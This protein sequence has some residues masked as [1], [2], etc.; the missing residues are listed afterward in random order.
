MAQ[1]PISRTARRPHRS[2]RRVV[3]TLG[4]AL[5]A[6]FVSLLPALPAQAKPTPAQLRAQITAQ[7]KV[8]EPI[9]EQYNTLRVKLADDQAKS[10]ALAKQLGPAQLLATTA[11]T[12]LG[13]IASTIYQSGGVSTAQ[14]LIGA[15]GSDQL[16]DVLGSLNEIARQQA[17]TIK[18]ASQI[19]ESYQTRSDTLNTLIAQEKQQYAQMN[20]QKASITAKVNGLQK[21]L[22]EANAGDNS[23]TGGG[24][25]VGSGPYTKSQL[26][27]AACPSGGSG[28]GLIAAKKACSLVWDVNHSPHWRMYHWGDAGPNTYDCSGLTMTAWAAAGV[29]LPHSASQQYNDTSS[30]GG[31]A[32]DLQVG[33]LIVYYSGHSH[34]AIYVGGGWIVQAEQ[35]FQ[36]LKMSKVAFT[37]PRFYRKVT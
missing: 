23:G 11:Q 36:P 27:P 17:A 26:M 16:I 6:A 2:A 20:S 34:V 33:D 14:A 32:S 25:N 29:S 30:R 13:V 7:N 10:K 35:S 8:L 12:R 18:D 21:L 28:K 37:G 4:T 3:V 5:L 31:S 15:G 1:P 22:D 9:I 19:L 24:N